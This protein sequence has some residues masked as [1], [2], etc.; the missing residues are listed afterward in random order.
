MGIYI[1]GKPVTSSKASFGSKSLR[2]KYAPCYLAKAFWISIG[3]NSVL[4]DKN[5]AYLRYFK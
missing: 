2:I 4:S 5:I 1:V 3:H